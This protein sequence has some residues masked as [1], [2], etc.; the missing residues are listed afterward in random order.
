MREIKSYRDLEA[1][2]RAMALAEEIYEITEH[3]PPRE[4]FG[5]AQ[6]LRRAGVSIPSN[7][8]EGH[9]RRSTQAYIYHLEIALGS[10]GEVETQAEL[11][12][13]RRFV[14]SAE[15]DLLVPLA[16]QS[17]QLL[18]GLIRGLE[19]SSRKF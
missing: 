1:W 2:Q 18:H 4:W 8:A 6:Q 16:E 9:C 12:Y 15:M 13:R 7:I 19:S 10:Q 14:T 5:L 11:A 3:F 17:G